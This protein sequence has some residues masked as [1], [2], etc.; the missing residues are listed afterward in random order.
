M[1]VSPRATVFEVEHRFYLRVD[2]EGRWVTYGERGVVFRRTLDGGVVLPRPSGP[3][4]L[5]DA[6][7]E[8]VHARVGRRASELLDLLDTNAVD[9]AALGD[10]ARARSRLAAAACWTGARREATRAAFDAAYPES[11]PILPPHRYRDLVL[12]PATGCPNHRCTFCAFYRDRPFRVLSDEAFEAHLQAV[13]VL[14]GRAL[15]DRDGI[16]LGSASALSLPDRLLKARLSRIDQVFGRPR[17]AVAAFYDADR[18]VLRPPDAW[19]ALA[20]RG[21]VEATVG[22]E[23]G[24]DVLRE[25]AGKSGD[26]DRLGHVLTAMKA[27]GLDVAL[28]VLLGLGGAAAE[29]EHRAQTIRFLRSL[30][31]TEGDRIYLSPLDGERG[32]EGLAGRWREGLEAAT[33]ARVGLY[34]IATFAFL[35]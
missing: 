11:A 23:T 29:A 17:R 8:A 33:P 15:D 10:A 27:G 18:G 30:P 1:R 21:L 24:W 5:E 22:L 2:A 6:E 7:R 26:L 14:F 13:R 4:H 16:F 3:R 35:A 25:Q 34:R 31:L 28:T 19:A 32:V 20:E 9:V 12:L